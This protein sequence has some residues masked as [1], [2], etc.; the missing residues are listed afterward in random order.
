MPITGAQE[1]AITPSNSA[2]KR[3]VK[4]LIRDRESLAYLRTNSKEKKLETG[5]YKDAVKFINELKLPTNVVVKCLPGNPDKSMIAELPQTGLCMV[6][7]EKFYLNIGNS[8]PD[9]DSVIRTGRYWLL[10][11][12]E[13]NPSVIRFK[14]DR[15]GVGLGP[16]LKNFF[17]QAT[18]FVSG[19]PE[20]SLRI[21][22]KIQDAL[23]NQFENR[24]YEEKAKRSIRHDE[25]FYNLLIKLV[26]KSKGLKREVKKFAFNEDLDREPKYDKGFRRNGVKKLVNAGV[27]VKEKNLNNWTAGVRV[28]DKVREQIGRYYPTF[29]QTGLDGG[30]V[31]FQGEK[32]KVLVTNPITSDLLLI[33]P[34][35]TNKEFR[36]ILK[37]IKRKYLETFT[38]LVSK[39]LKRKL[40]KENKVFFLDL[41][42]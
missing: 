4:D 9:T 33:N 26:A 22:N 36:K 23:R 35:I 10:N 37:G 40:E 21:F 20:N 13:N 32:E 11:D 28:Y 1:L 27:L 25:R 2:V 17:H 29:F 3:F 39:A 12:G 18:I 16:D 30:Y 5:L 34:D 19:E 24:Y 31:K 6:L 38:S 8:E 15:K 14:S 7:D 42:R 41:E